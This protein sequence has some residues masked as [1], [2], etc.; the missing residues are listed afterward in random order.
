ML[1]SGVIPIDDALRVLVTMAVWFVVSLLK[2]GWLTSRRSRFPFPKYCLC[3]VGNGLLWIF[4]TTPARITGCLEG[5]IQL[6]SKPNRKISN[7]SLDAEDFHW[8]PLD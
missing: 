1:L 3:A 2:G 4:V 8:L 7:L 6:F 5:V